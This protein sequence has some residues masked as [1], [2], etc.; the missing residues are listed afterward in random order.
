MA[1]GFPFALCLRQGA[2]AEEVV[3]FLVDLRPRRRVLV[4]L[5]AFHVGAADRV[6][7][8]G[9]G[10]ELLVKM[11]ISITVDDLLKVVRPTT[12]P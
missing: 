7:C 8:K 10:R 1:C 12:Y 3:D 5:K 4:P 2:T 6:P 11:G 9:L